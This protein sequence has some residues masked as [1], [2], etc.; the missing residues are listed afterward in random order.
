MSNYGWG[1]IILAILICLVL[2]FGIFAGTAWLICWAFHLTFT[3]R[4][5][6]GCW[7]VFNLLKSIFSITVKKD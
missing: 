2:S 3:W 4:V 6:I 1:G 7:L 5:V